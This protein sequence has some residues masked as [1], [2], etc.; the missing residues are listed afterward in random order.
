MKHKYLL[1]ITIALFLVVN[2]NYYWEGTAGL[3]AFPIFIFLG[4]VFIILTVLFTY[5]LIKGIKEKFKSRDRLILISAM[6]ILLGLILY[7]PNGIIDFEKFEGE[8]LLIANAEGVASCMTTLKLKS[9]NKFI[10][11]TICFGV[12]KVDGLFT[13]QNDTIF[14]TN[15]NHEKHTDY[16]EF[17]V[18]GPHH[19]NYIG[20]SGDLKLYKN[21]NDSLIKRLFIR[22]NDLNKL[23]K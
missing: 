9:S 8:D 4:L 21:K 1:I 6:F 23:R 12:K 18:I 13:V 3:L 10:E 20:V 5:H 16:Y 11:R 7:K 22:K 15:F 17:G 14:F 2:L 19:Y